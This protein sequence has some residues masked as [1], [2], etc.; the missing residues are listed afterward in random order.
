MPVSSNERIRGTRMR[1]GRVVVGIGCK[2]E[3]CWDR[4]QA[5]IYG[6]RLSGAWRTTICLM[7]MQMGFLRSL[8]VPTLVRVID[9]DFNGSVGGLEIRSLTIVDWDSAS[10]PPTALFSSP[11]CMIHYP[12]SESPLALGFG[13]ASV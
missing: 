1:R 6:S 4:G 12:K 3:F 9:I 8:V 7:H 11:H 2:Y 10:P 5:R 13:E